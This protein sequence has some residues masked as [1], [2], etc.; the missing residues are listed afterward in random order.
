MRRAARPLLQSRGH[1]AMGTIPGRAWLDF[2]RH[3][4]GFAMSGRYQTTPKFWNNAYEREG[5]L[6][7]LEWAG[8]GF[9]DLETYAYRDALR[10]GAAST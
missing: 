9:R 10:G 2:L 5:G 1:R 6:R 3:R 4:V 7:P 8:V